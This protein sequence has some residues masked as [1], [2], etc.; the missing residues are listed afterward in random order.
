MRL[1]Q[2]HELIDSELAAGTVDGGGALI[3]LFRNQDAPIDSDDGWTEVAVL[4]LE[5]DHESEDLDLAT[6]ASEPRS[7][8]ALTD[9]SSMLADMLAE[10][11]GY[12]VRLEGEHH[13][14][15]DGWGYFAHMAVI[16]SAIDSEKRRLAVIAE[17]EGFDQEF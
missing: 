9:L 4:E 3:G 7:P 5:L 11:G 13:E 8:L 17:Y 2:L 14:V 12:C 10:Y 15:R 16:G 6:F 1:H